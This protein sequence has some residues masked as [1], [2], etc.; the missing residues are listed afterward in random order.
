MQTLVKGATQVSTGAASLYT[1]LQTLSASTSKL[2]AGAKAVYEGTLALQ[3]GSA[4]LVEGA[5]K[6]SAG[7]MQ[8]YNGAVTFS[9]K[10]AE[11][12]TGAKKLAAG[13]NTLDSSLN[14]AVNKLTSQMSSMGSGSLLKAL[15][16]VE[17]IQDAA[18]SYDS[19]GSGSYKTVTF[20]Y[21][22][23]EVSPK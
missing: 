19:F 20:I 7:S 6:L 17:S 14:T 12:A 16:N 23:D 1:G 21:K 2:A 11:M 22:T 13:A 3:G 15:K 9:N 4:A 8:I 10:E 18:K 5:N